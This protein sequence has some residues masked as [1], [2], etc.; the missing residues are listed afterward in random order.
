M[1]VMQ[2]YHN[3][4]FILVVKWVMIVVV[5]LSREQRREYWVKV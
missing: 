4:S 3:K 2:I 5:I 1:L